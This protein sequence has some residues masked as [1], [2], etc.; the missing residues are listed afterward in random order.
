[1]NRLK[2]LLVLALLI[3]GSANYTDTGRRYAINLSHFVLTSYLNAKEKVL[4]KID[5][6]F[7]QQEE[8]KTLRAKNK[9]LE[10]SALLSIAFAAKL[11]AIMADN[12]LSRYQPNVKMIQ[13]LSYANLND[14]NRVWLDFQDF[15]QSKIYG[16]LYQGYAAGIAVA[17]NTKALGLLLGD[18]QCIFSVYVGDQKIPGVLQGNK[19]DILVKYI[20]LW[21]N[22]KIGDEVITSGMDDIFFQG[23]RVGKVIRVAEEESSK[24]VTVRPY[25]NMNIPTFLHIITKN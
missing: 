2:F 20:P 21:M 8:I 15:N 14:Y 19:K 25:V 11:N 4:N 12:N 17:K 16:L 7:S 24:T 18:P 23:V 9:K 13:A 3:Y 10:K 5:E 1:M 22:P 6:H